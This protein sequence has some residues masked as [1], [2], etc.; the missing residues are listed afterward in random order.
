MLAET[1]CTNTDSVGEGFG[2]SLGYALFRAQVEQ[3][4][5]IWLILSVIFLS[6]AIK[7]MSNMIPATCSLLS[8]VKVSWQAG[9]HLN[10]I[11]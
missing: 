3:M 1:L 9:H 10:I 8:H 6:L 4:P 2:P 7:H 5:P 11:C